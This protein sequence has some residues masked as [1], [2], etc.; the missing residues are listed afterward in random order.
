MR[1]HSHYQTSGTGH[2]YQG[3]F[4]SFP[5][6]VDEHLLT[7]MRYVER[8]PVRAKLSQLAGTWKWGSA[9]Q[10]QQPT[11]KQAVWLSHLNVPWLPRR[12]RSLV[13]QPQT[14][15]EQKEIRNCISR[16]SPYGDREWQKQSAVRLGL[17]ST[18]DKRGRPRKEN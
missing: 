9:W 11:S 1:W 17:N 15:A 14:D 8:N 2:L 12:W 3:R 16:G 6:Q 4:N 13:N 5:V 7:V 18:L 10:R